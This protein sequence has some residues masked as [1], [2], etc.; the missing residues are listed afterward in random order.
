[1]LSSREAFLLVP[2]VPHLDAMR[3]ET[4]N[5]T[6]GLSNVLPRIPSLPRQERRI[7]FRNSFERT[8]VSSQPS[9]ST[10]S[11]DIVSRRVGFQQNSVVSLQ[12]EI[13][14]QRW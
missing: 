2:S 5:E 7:H 6:K 3:L 12:V 4:T 11:E 1:M 10:E 8:D 9:P 13:V 14:T